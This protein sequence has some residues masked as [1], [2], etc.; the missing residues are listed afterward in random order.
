MKSDAWLWQLYNLNNISLLM[1]EGSFW[2][3]EVTMI[4]AREKEIRLGFLLCKMQMSNVLLYAPA[5]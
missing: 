3:G 4:M 1:R 2:S 5:D